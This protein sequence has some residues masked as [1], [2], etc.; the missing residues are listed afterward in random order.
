MKRSE[1]KQLIKEELN[2]IFKIDPS[3]AFKIYDILSKK[4][5]EIKKEFTGSAFFHYL[6]N[7]L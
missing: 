4:V 2:D 3:T 6:N 5:P 1:L 7:N